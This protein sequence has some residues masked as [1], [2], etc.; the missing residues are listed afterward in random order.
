MAQIQPLLAHYTHTHTWWPHTAMRGLGRCGAGIQLSPHAAIRR[1]RSVTAGA[2]VGAISGVRRLHELH[3]LA[4][5]AGIVSN[6]RLSHGHTVTA[7]RG[8][9]IRG[10]ARR[11]LRRSPWRTQRPVCILSMLLPPP[12]GGAGSHTGDLAV[13]H[14][15]CAPRLSPTAGDGQ[16]GALPYC[17]DW[18]NK[19]GSL[20]HQC[21]PGFFAIA[22]A[23]HPDWALHICRRL[24]LPST[25]GPLHNF[26]QDIIDAAGMLA[27]GCASLLPADG[28]LSRKHASPTSRSSSPRKRPEASRE[29]SEGANGSLSPLHDLSP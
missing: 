28:I 9:R 24:S 25:S 17:A 27:M 18:N 11:L 12:A 20:P 15:S 7:V 16:C 14:A 6:A 3:A 5:P 1:L 22:H 8:V 19:P 10:H 26:C 4:V 29:A 2:A 21:A 13:D 23:W